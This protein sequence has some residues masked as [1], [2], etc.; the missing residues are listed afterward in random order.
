MMAISGRTS[1]TG[2]KASTHPTPSPEIVRIKREVTDKMSLNKEG[3]PTDPNEV[4]PQVHKKR[5]V[6]IQKKK[7]HPVTQDTPIPDIRVLKSQRSALRILHINQRTKFLRE[8]VFRGLL[9]PRYGIR[10]LFTRI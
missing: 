5:T 4:V 9:P 10:H 8:K 1:K 3:E 2:S 6:V 7:V